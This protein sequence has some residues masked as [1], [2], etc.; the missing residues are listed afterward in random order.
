MHDI[1]TVLP[2]IQRAAKRVAGKWPQ[3]T[4]EEDMVQV[5]SLHFL[6]APGALEALIKLTP[7]KR[8]GRLIGIGHDK[9]SGQRDDLEV[10]SGQFTY[11][12]DE[13]RKLLERGALDG[14]VDRY[15]AATA[16]IETAYGELQAKNEGHAKALHSRYVLNVVPA[17]QSAERFVLDRAV[18]SLTT[19]MN[20]VSRSA[21]YQ[22][23]NGGRFRNNRMAVNQSD[24]D[25]EGVDGRFDERRPG[26]ELD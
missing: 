4:T 15:D 2:D 25:Y 19:H 18:D 24:W 12:V 17:N 20:R 9:A 26:R 5:L 11:S 23:T 22:F 6:E 16:D 3:V 21:R 10:F 8:L 13:V 1:E 14:Q 7:D